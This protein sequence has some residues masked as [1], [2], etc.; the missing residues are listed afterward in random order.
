MFQLQAQCSSFLSVTV[1]EYLSGEK[2]YSFY[3]PRHNVRYWREV[4][5]GTLNYH[6]ISMMKNRERKMHLYFLAS[7][8]LA[9]FTLLQVPL[10]REW[11]Y[12]Q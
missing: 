5:A 7:A 12:P 9:F 3:N 2:V 6:I 10:P 8:H 4:K 1:T 11:Y